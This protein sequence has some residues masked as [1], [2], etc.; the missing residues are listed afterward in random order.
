EDGAQQAGPGRTPV[1]GP[2]HAAHHLAAEPPAAAFVGNGKAPT[3][4]PMAPARKHR[5]G[6]GACAYDDDAA[7][8]ATMR[9]NARSVRVCRHHHVPEWMSIGLD[10][11]AFD[12]LRRPRQGEAGDDGAGADTRLGL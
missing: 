1:I 4:H 8:L 9:S 2:Q 12:R 7:V 3:A 5:P 11:L 10:G 6:Y